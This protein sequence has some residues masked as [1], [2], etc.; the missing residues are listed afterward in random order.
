MQIREEI[1]EGKVLTWR[2]CRERYESWYPGPPKRPP[3]GS[4]A[5]Y[6]RVTRASGSWSRS[7]KGDKQVNGGRYE[8][9]GGAGIRTCICRAMP[10]A[11]RKL[12][13]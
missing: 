1:D 7:K 12:S 11:I 9:K 3:L 5:A 6:M 4:W 10:M 2:S 13:W 8:G